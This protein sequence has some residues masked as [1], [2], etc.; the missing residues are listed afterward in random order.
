MAAALS[1]VKVDSQTS[2][3]M[4]N[5][6]NLLNTRVGNFLQAISKDQDVNM[7]VV[8]TAKHNKDKAA[9]LVDALKRLLKPLPNLK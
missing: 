7:M 3:A 1:L 8:I 2:S 6:E 9:D 4:E 5:E